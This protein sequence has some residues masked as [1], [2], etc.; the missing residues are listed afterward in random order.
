VHPWPLGQ[1]KCSHFSYKCSNTT[2]PYKGSERGKC[3]QIARFHRDSKRM[4][5]LFTRTVRCG[6]FLFTRGC[7]FTDNDIWAHFRAGPVAR[8]SCRR[9]SLSLVLVVVCWRRENPRSALVL[10]PQIPVWCLLSRL[11][12]PPLS[13]P[14][15]PPAAASPPS[16]F[17]AASGRR[18]RAAAVAPQQLLPCIGR[19]WAE[20]LGR[21]M[22]SRAPL[23]RAPGSAGCCQSRST[24]PSQVRLPSVL[25]LFS[26]LGRSLVFP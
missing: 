23:R 17:R 8:G 25:F 20:D 4:P 5:P 6:H 11:L 14:S 10:L 22:R 15:T 1:K 21:A 24:T 7:S 2:R 13:R 26:F 3:I 19:S 9:S 12:S 18:P 16:T